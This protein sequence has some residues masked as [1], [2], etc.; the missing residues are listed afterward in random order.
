LK[1]KGFTLIELLIVVA[2][3]GILAAIAIP[4]FLEAQVRAKVARAKADERSVSLAYETYRVDY[5]AYPVCDVLLPFTGINTPNRVMLKYS[6][7][8]DL[9][10]YDGYWPTDLTTPTSYISSLPKDPFPTKV[11][12]DTGLVGGPFAVGEPEAKRN[13]MTWLWPYGRRVIPGMTPVNAN[14]YY[15]LLSPGPTQAMTLGFEWA[16]D[17]LASKAIYDP[18]NGTISIGNITRF[19]P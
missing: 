14:I 12:D 5:N 13:Y 10:V 6:G 15:A 8:G 18:T 2:I 9:L 16:V 11:W 3:I 17:E 1:G 7:F 19:G 4:N